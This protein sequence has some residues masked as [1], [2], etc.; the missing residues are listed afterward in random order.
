MGW[1]LG[2]RLGKGGWMGP[3]RVEQDWTEFGWQEGWRII[4]TSCLMAS[5]STFSLLMAV[6]SLG[7]LFIK[8]VSP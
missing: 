1:G 8:H 4:I 7:W 2:V 3:D 5:N 6:E